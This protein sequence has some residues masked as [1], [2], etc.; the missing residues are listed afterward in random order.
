MQLSLV[1]PCYNEQDVI[2]EFYKRTSSACQSVVKN[3]YELI[4]I[5]DGSKD[6]T[7]NILTKFAH[8]DRHVVCIDLLRNHG[9]Q[10]AVTAGLQYAKGDRVMIIDAD[11]QDPPELLPQF[12]EKMDEGYDVV[13]GQRTCR[14]GESSFKLMT[15]SLFYK[16]L[17]FF[18][19][20]PIPK[21][22]GDFRLITKKVASI[23]NDM[24]EQQRFLRGMMAWVGGRQ[25][26]L[27]YE[28]PARFAG[29]TKYPFFKMIRLALDGITGFSIAPLKLGI[30]LA[31]LGML[32][33][34]P[35]TFYVLDGLLFNNAI[36]GWASL[37]LLIT[38][39]SS[40]QLL[41]IGIIG[42][43]V[44][45]LYLE[46][47]KRPLVMVRKVIKKDTKGKEPEKKL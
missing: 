1:V 10:L 23:I 11:L 24:P 37:A 32:C 19:S 43:Y 38:F 26:P 4:F 46:V 36:P 9:H 8:A 14:A 18:S 2:E 25:I 22:T 15:A 31:F 39:F 28:R 44:G 42:E 45:R 47:K 17:N 35:L 7:L 3:S 41:C 27:Y 29:T 30:W 13:Y 33:S 16:I 20:I 34:V 40:I 6:N 12:M 21:D 5:N